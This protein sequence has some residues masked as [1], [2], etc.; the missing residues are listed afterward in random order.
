MRQH[1]PVRAAV[2]AL[3]LAGLVCLP[4]C[5][6]AGPSP[7]SSAGTGPAVSLSP[8]PVEP[9]PPGE[10]L[11]EIPLY[12]TLYLEEGQLAD[13]MAVKGDILF[14]SVYSTYGMD[15]PLF[16]EQGY[17][18]FTERLTLYDVSKNQ[19]L[20]SWKVGEGE[21]CTSGAFVGQALV[22]TTV[23]SPTNGL[24]DAEYK[25]YKTTGGPDGPVSQVLA[26]APCFATGYD[27][28]RVIALDGDH[29]ACSYF[30]PETQTFGVNVVSLSQGT[31]TPQITLV[32]DGVTEHLKTTLSGNGSEYIYYAA[33]DGK[34]TVFVGGVDGLEHQFSIPESE[35]VYY[36]CFLDNAILFTMETFSAR[37][38]RSTEIIVKTLEGETV[39]SLEHKPLYRL[40]SNG[41]DRVLGIDQSYQVMQ[42][43]VDG[44]EIS[45]MEIETPTQ[46][47]VLFYH[48]ADSRFYLHFNNDLRGEYRL[49]LFL[50]D[51][52]GGTV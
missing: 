46:Y 18:A 10:T 48:K 16:N 8:A 15:H 41:R 39:A 44:G 30:E 32:D 24:L 23:Y 17:N 29:F 28:P 47:A 5:A 20:T 25:I 34:G 37:G 31:V 7:S 33:V 12:E 40:V 6:P 2:A 13:I 35:R 52:S 14:L 26:E 45:T 9:S 43:N 3:L 51:A 19:I 4:S 38:E 42:I 21:L 36:S 50:L 22:Y 27:D 11:T 1:H 49:G